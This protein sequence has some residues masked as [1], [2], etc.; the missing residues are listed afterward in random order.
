MA[1]D[2]KERLSPTFFGLRQDWNLEC[3][4]DDAIQQTHSHHRFDKRLAPQTRRSGVGPTAFTSSSVSSIVIIIVPVILA[5]SLVV[6]PRWWRDRM[7]SKARFFVRFARWSTRVATTPK[8]TR[9]IGLSSTG[10]CSH[11]HPVKG[12]VVNVGYVTQS[13]LDRMLN[14]ERRPNDR[15]RPRGQ[16]G[17][18][19]GEELQK[20][21]VTGCVL[22][23]SCGVSRFL[24]AVFR[25]PV[26]PKPV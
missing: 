24:T 26:A 5:R 7:C 16:Q 8:S 19:I 4:G 13:D 25:F 2:R 15:S 17:L 1:L 3:P 10:S 12:R 22:C 14:W 21:L 20:T 6:R 11:E 23:S 9:S 18:R